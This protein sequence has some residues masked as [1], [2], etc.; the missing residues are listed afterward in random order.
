MSNSLMQ[1]RVRHHASNASVI[2]EL[3]CHEL[4]VSV[5]GLFLCGLFNEHRHAVQVASP[6]SSWQHWLCSVSR[7]AASGVR[8]R[9]RG[10]RL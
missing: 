1:L 9:L 3:R 8:S 4:A 7:S 2:P 6:P 5:L 10:T